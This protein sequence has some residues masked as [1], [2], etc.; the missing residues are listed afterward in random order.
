MQRY[1]G[2]YYGVKRDDITGKPRPTKVCI[3]NT[4]GEEVAHYDLKV[5]T[6]EL[7]FIKGQYVSAWRIAT[8]QDDFS[9]CKRV[10][11]KFLAPKNKKPQHIDERFLQL[12]ETGS[13]P[14]WYEITHVPVQYDG[15]MEGDRVV[16]IL[17]G[18]GNR[19]AFAASLRAEKMNDVK[20]FHCPGRIIKEQRDT[21]KELAVEKFLAQTALLNA[22]YLLPVVARD[23]DVI[24]VKLYFYK[25][26]NAQAARKAA[27]NRARATFEGEIFCSEDGLYPDAELEF[28]F[29]EVAF[30]SFTLQTHVTEEKQSYKRLMDLMEK[31]TLFN[32]V[33]SPIE[34]M[35]PRIAAAI[36]ASIGSIT[37]F[38]NDANFKSYCG[39]APDKHGKFRRARKGQSVNYSPQ[40]RQALYLFADQCLKRANSQWGRKLRE[41]KARLRA[42]HPEKIMNEHGKWV[43]TDGH[44]HKMACWH[45]LGKFAEYLFKQWRDWEARQQEIDK[46]EQAS[47][48]G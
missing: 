44:I 13:E 14:G 4:K 39:V 41:Q 11:R 27:F 29:D 28:L 21:E 46:G 47:A 48:A 8:V 43:Y 25:F 1:I 20:V 23:R 45:M 12:I 32:E 24:S 31:L 42:K 35:G 16:V 33:F 7:D 3:W 6:E 30:N 26:V 9:K 17:Q 40:A 38:K 37:K 5:A 15:I 22:T 19:F 10:F 36:I 18:V 34:G 2:I